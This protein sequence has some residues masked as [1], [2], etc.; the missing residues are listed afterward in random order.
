MRELKDSCEISAAV[1]MALEQLNGQGE[2]L[3]LVG[4]EERSCTIIN[5]AEV[6][7]RDMRQIEIEM[8]MGWDED[9]NEEREPRTFKVSFTATVEEV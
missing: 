3:V 6:V 2:L 8:D 5:A 1:G 9:K 7:R 4:D